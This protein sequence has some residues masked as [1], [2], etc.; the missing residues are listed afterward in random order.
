MEIHSDEAIPQT[1]S[2]AARSWDLGDAE[3]AAPPQSSSQDPPPFHAISKR[4]ADQEI[5][6]TYIKRRVEEVYD[7]TAHTAASCTMNK[8][9]ATNSRQGAVDFYNIGMMATRDE[10]TKE[11]EDVLRQIEVH[12]SQVI[13][14]QRKRL[15]FCFGFSESTLELGRTS[16][17]T[18]TGASTKKNVRH[19]GSQRPSAELRREHVACRS[20]TSKCYKKT[21]SLSNDA[22]GR[23]C[24][25][26]NNRFNDGKHNRS[27]RFSQ[28]G[29]ARGKK[30]SASGTAAT[31]QREREHRLEGLRKEITNK[32][33]LYDK[34]GASA[35]VSQATSKEGNKRGDSSVLHEDP[36]CSSIAL[37]PYSSPH[38]NDK[39]IAS[40]PQTAAA[41]GFYRKRKD[42][43]EDISLF[44]NDLSEH[45]SKRTISVSV[46]RGE[47][48]P[49]VVQMYPP[50][51]GSSATTQHP[52][53]SARDTE[54]RPLSDA[55]DGGVRPELVDSLVQRLH[56][57]GRTSE[58]SSVVE[59]SS[60]AA[61]AAIDIPTGTFLLRGPYDPP[62]PVTP[63]NGNEESERV[64]ASTGPPRRAQGEYDGQ[65]GASLATNGKVRQASTTLPKQL[66]E[67]NKKLHSTPPA[68]EK[69][70]DAVHNDADDFDNVLLRAERCSPAP[71]SFPTSDDVPKASMREGP[72]SVRK[73]G[74]E[75]DVCGN[76]SLPQKKRG[77]KG[78]LRGRLQRQDNVISP[79]NAS[80]LAASSSLV[81]ER[82]THSMPSSRFTAGDMCVSSRYNGRSASG[83]ARMQRV[84]GR[85]ATV[86]AAEQ[87][88]KSFPGNDGGDGDDGGEVPNSHYC[89]LRQAM[90]SSAA[91]KDE[92]SVAGPDTRQPPSSAHHFRRLRRPF[93][94]LSTRALLKEING[95]WN[96]PAGAKNTSR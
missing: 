2:C 32:N 17:A 83:V 48:T 53:Q 80:R 19:T 64:S 42:K 89:E 60:P 66:L 84:S 75:R 88:K 74:T 50:V 30:G 29:Y 4:D 59:D 86:R 22:L 65:R 82:G 18:S 12:L 95:M 55:S 26:A 79:R 21:K 35:S 13:H 27:K 68:P 45:P 43:S 81:L 92:Q 61:S 57:P 24:H 85:N 69:R 38:C 49:T 25:G 33:N 37:L 46:E 62:L 93:E 20:N 16:N 71:F 15:N 96:R 41:G 8:D 1:N 6:H 73:M 70:H 3:V 76:V 39:P 44:M 36:T 94:N 10:A 47:I 58:P 14:L 87:Q 11:S 28:V 23:A 7:V 56:I 31:R 54:C 9:D 67:K 77:G 63:A 40:P 5:S 34:D 72:R 91:R 52:E 51:L 90:D 78:V